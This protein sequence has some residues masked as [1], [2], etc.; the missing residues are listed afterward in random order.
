MSTILFKFY[1]NLLYVFIKKQKEHVF[2]Q[3]IS[4]YNECSICDYC[5]RRKSMETQKITATVDG[6]SYQK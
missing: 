1:S 6:V 2:K 5:W 3:W 4:N